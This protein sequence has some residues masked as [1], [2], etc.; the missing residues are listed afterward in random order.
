MKLKL[1]LYARSII[2]GWQRLRERYLHHLSRN[3]LCYASYV[4]FPTSTAMFKFPMCLKVVYLLNSG[5]RQYVIALKICYLRW[6][7]SNLNRFYMSNVFQTSRYDTSDEFDNRFFHWLAGTSI[8][9]FF[10]FI[11]LLLRAFF[12]RYCNLSYIYL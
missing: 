8:L 4:C 3:E 2:K 10:C 1:N 9:F 11:F 7:L 12:I 5:I 6:W